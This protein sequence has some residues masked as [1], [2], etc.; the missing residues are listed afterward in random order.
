MK[1]NESFISEQFKDPFGILKIQEKYDYDSFLHERYLIGWS[2]TSTDFEWAFKPLEVEPDSLRLFRDYAR[3]MFREYKLSEVVESNDD[4]FR[5]WISDSITRTDDGPMVNRTLL[6]DLS[7][8]DSLRPMMER[9]EVSPLRFSRSI[10]QVEPGNVRDTWQCFPDTLFVVKRVSH[11]LRQVLEPIPFSGM[12]SPRKYIQRQKLLKKKGTFLMFDFKKC[13][14]TV[15]REL[16]AILGEELELLYPGKGFNEMTYFRNIVVENEG[17]P[18][19]PIRGVGLG[20]CNEGVTLI[21]CVIGY[22]LYKKRG[23]DS[24]FFNDDGAIF[25][26]GEDERKAFTLALTQFNRIGMIINLEKTVFSTFNV[27]CEDYVTDKTLDYT[28][29]QL[30]I[31]PFVDCF[32]IAKQIISKNT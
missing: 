29:T 8:T 24:I 6:R 13:G 31:I 11:L 14:L 7:S 15:N 20:N 28:K 10:V 21:Q 27:F 18:M 23:F 2:E 4:D 19:R 26:P 5:H 22:M 17:N 16:I 1:S 3:S 12:C 25:T 30:L 9:H 32:L